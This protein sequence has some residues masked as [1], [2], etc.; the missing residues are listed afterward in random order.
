MRIIDSSY[1]TFIDLELR[2]NLFTLY[3][4]RSGKREATKVRT[5]TESENNLSNS[6]DTVYDH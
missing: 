2:A 1:W 3:I 6:Q 4:D 5:D